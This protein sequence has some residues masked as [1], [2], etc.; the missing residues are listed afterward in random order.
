MVFDG[1]HIGDIYI[2]ENSV[3]REL[4]AKIVFIF[5]INNNLNHIFTLRIKSQSAWW[6]YCNN[7]SRLI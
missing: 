7:T 2:F 5:Y 3:I 6:D 1:K 4:S